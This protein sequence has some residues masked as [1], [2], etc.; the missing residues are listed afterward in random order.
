MLSP[1]LVSPTAYDDL[2]NSIS[3]Y[4]F[5]ADIIVSVAA[6]D[7]SNPDEISLDDDEVAMVSSN[8]DE[9]PQGTSNPYTRPHIHTPTHT[10]TQMLVWEDG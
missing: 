3:L 1:V 10:P 4:L 2:R 6:G 7:V 8:P 5:C 9:M